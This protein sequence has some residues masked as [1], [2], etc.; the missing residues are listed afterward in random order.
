VSLRRGLTPLLALAL[1]ALLAPGAGAAPADSTSAGGRCG[2]CH[3]EERVKFANSRHASEA[4]TCVSCHGGD[5]TSV[6]QARAHGRNFRGRPSRRDIPAL[7]ASCHADEDRMRAY[8]LPVDQYALYQTSGHGRRLARGDARVAVCSDCHGAHDI[9]A[10]ADPASR[11]YVVNIPRTCGECHGKAALMKATP[12]KGQVYGEYMGS[13]HAKAL[14]DRGN[15]KAPNCTSCH[16]VHGAAPPAVG[17]VDKVCGQCH[18]AERRYFAAGPHRAR[19]LARKLPECASCHGDH[20]V[21]AADPARLASQCTLCH[22]S[23]SMQE[24]LGARMYADYRSAAQEIAAAEA[25]IARADA[26][27]LPTE[28]Y[29]SRLEEARTLLS[30][31]MPAA[32]SVREEIVAS[33]T[34]RARSVGHEIESEIG[35]K[36]AD[37]RWRYVGLALFWFYLGLT[38]VIL[39][40]FQGRDTRNR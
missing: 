1:T 31:A 33:F 16:G 19:M 37:L 13:V 5:A 4:V 23:D 18:T 28:D 10:A 3:P 38:I 11:V 30:E 15:L 26:V 25:V 6:D 12:H 9:L 7:C 39:R 36:L 22:G 35:H 20:G 17:D 40:R 32:H 2:V 21:P 8:N 24:Q 34:S 14:Y 29:K 27:P